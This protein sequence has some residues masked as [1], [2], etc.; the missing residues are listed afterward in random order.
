MKNTKQLL[1][2][3]KKMIEFEAQKYAQFV[4]LTVARVEAYRLA[5]MAAESYDEK[6]GTKFSTYLTNYL[7]KLSRISTQYGAAVRLPEQKQFEVHKLNQA[8]Q[9]L[10]EELGRP[11]SAQE[12]SEYAGVPLAKVNSLLT[13]RK[14]EVNINNLAYTPV[15]LQNSRWDDQVHFAYH[16]LP[17]RDKVIFEHSTGFGGKPVLTTE[18]IAKKL[19][20]SPSTVSNRLNLINKKMNLEE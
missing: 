16:D 1:E 10:H 11:A 13:N 12:L 7:K 9:H 3:H 15:F 8:E 19:S 17:D 4:P 6:S 5:S 18:Q 2:D 14:K 20:L